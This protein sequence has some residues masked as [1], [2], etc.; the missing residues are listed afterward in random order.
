MTNQTPAA[1]GHN[2]RVALVSLGCDKNLMDSEVMLGLLQEAGYG[3][4]ADQSQADILILNTCGF[5]ADA[6]SESYQTARELASYKKSGRCK[7][8]IIT[9]CMAQRYRDEILVKIPEAD[10][11]LGTGDY[12]GILVAIEGALAGRKTVFVSD[13][14]KDISEEARH[15]R[16][17]STPGHFAYIKI[18][19]GCDNHCTYCTIPS[20][21]GRYRSRPK[22]SLLA[23]AEA[24]ARQGV[25]ELV[26]VAQDTS[27]YGTELYGQNSIHE[28]LHSFSCIEGIEWIR[29]LYCYPEHI[30]D[31]LI[32]EMARNPKICHYVD[33]PIQHAA[34]AILKRMGRRSRQAQ[35]R[36]VIRRLRERMPDITLRTTLITGFPGET[37]EHFTDLLQFVRDIRFDRLGVF[38]YSK[39]EGTPAAAM[40]GQVPDKLKNRRRDRL[41]GEQQGI[42]AEKNAEK[43]GKVYQ[44]LVEGRLPDDPGTYFGRTAMDCPEADGL[45]FFP[46]GVHVK[47]GQFVPVRIVDAT[48]YDLMGE[49]AD[50][51]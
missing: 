26:V 11:V 21:R 36:D 7:A 10:G 24:L 50:E 44:I 8:L 49:I 41:M 48:A 42:S 35:I 23:E 51:A 39:E 22:E 4:T 43:A 12:E 32:D 9:G 34:D 14:N 18:A 27:L 31:A 1:E 13:I 5:I 28:L 15:K 2:L 47:P 29:L 30:T 6:V 45:V 20:L 38:A 37:E 16:V 17:I 3:L 19:E 40:P 46:A 33:M 25:R